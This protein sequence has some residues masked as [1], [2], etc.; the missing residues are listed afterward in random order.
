[1][2]KMRRIFPGLFALLL[3][4][5]IVLPV[6]AELPEQAKDDIYTRGFNLDGNIDVWFSCVLDR[7]SGDIVKN[8]VYNGA[9]TEYYTHNI[10]SYGTFYPG[11]CTQDY[12]R[13]ITIS[14]IVD[15][16]TYE[17]TFTVLNSPAGHYWDTE[18]TAD[19]EKGTHYHK[20]LRDGCNGR[21]DEDDHTFGKWTPDE[22][23]NNHK[24][25]CSVCFA[26]ETGGHTVSSWTAVE[27]TN[28]HQGTCSVC[29][30]VV[31][32]EHNFSFS[33]HNAEGE[34]HLCNRC[35][36]V[37]GPPQEH[38]WE[39]RWCDAKDG[40]HYRRCTT[41][42][43]LS[44]PVA[45][46]YVLTDIGG[47]YHQKKCVCGA[48]EGEA[49]KHS[50][51]GWTPVEGTGTHQGTCDCGAVFT[52]DCSGGT[53]TC[54]A[55]A[56]CE[57]CGQSYGEK[58]PDNHDLQHVDKKDPTCTDPGGAASDYCTRCDYPTYAEKKALD[59]DLQH[60]DKKDPTC[61]EIGWDAYDYCTR[62][63]YTTY[64][65]K[66]ALDHDLVH[67][68]RKDATCTEPGWEAYD[69]CKRE[70]CGYTTYVEIPAPGH[71]PGD[72][73]EENRVEPAPGKEG[74]VDH[75]TYCTACGVEL[76][77]ETETL[78][79]LPVIIEPKPELQ[80]VPADETTETLA[81]EVQEA[82]DSGDVL[83]L[84][85]E[86][87]KAEIPEGF[88][89]LADLVSAKLVNFRNQAGEVSVRMMPEIPY[90][91]GTEVY[92]VIMVPGEEGP[93]FFGAEG[94]AVKDGSLRIR[95]D[96]EILKNLKDKTFVVMVLSK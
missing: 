26:E 15:G 16:K 56:V 21:S 2:E 95:L 7:E 20:C 46:E 89:S 67:T 70:G 17:R 61:T 71:V 43:M 63:D 78:A 4:L 77:R 50:F 55:Q 19:E 68:D 25:V 3:A 38:H 13:Q 45:H 82:A 37:D 53:A 94:T 1:M 85:P 57:T 84:L 62:C 42:D 60:V 80:V 22:K 83:S 69:A 58:D 9:R 66:K 88:I 30:A 12:S 33:S 59:H 64:V 23:N 10:T 75:V 28:T 52:E 11:G 49:A 93:L 18:W 65:E 51:T 27:G 90:E 81:A 40:T 39:D 36:A 92:V 8:G 86:E 96:A 41:C 24:R 91:A 44:V 35:W 72:P 76:A 73:A 79:A 14:M 31:T 54:A 32:E 47:G 74:S 5:L 87:L 6:Q 29:S 48:V 34:W